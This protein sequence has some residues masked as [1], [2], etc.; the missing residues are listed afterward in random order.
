MAQL[1]NI[2]RSCCIENATGDFVYIL[3]GRFLQNYL[4]PPSATSY[5]HPKYA[6]SPNLP[7]LKPLLPVLAISD[8]PWPPQCAEKMS[9]KTKKKARTRGVAG[10]ANPARPRGRAAP[11][12]CPDMPA[13]R[14]RRFGG[15]LPARR[16]P[17][18]VGRRL[19]P[20]PRAPLGKTRGNQGIPI[21]SRLSFLQA[22]PSFFS[23]HHAEG[24]EESAG[25][26]P[27]ELL[28]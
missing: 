21:S 17:A 25:P 16:D 7:L 20:R 24:E 28:V 19:R 9:G 18:A 22:F 14:S 23:E 27:S 5:P 4:V 12:Y 13:Q 6:S 3:A 8:L 10:D 1:V 11:H 15:A 26:A 2:A